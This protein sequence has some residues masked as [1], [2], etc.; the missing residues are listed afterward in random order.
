MSS[1]RYSIFL[2][3]AAAIALLT[4]RAEAKCRLEPYR[5]EVEIRSSRTRKPV[6]GVRLA[7]FANGSETGMPSGSAPSQTT[8]G[9]DGKSARTYLFDTYSGSGVLHAER[10]K[11]QLRTLEVV[12]VHPDYQVRRV[13]LKR[14]AIS[15]QAA[16]DVARIVIPPVLMDPFEQP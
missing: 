4:A 1:I 14:V 11:A 16:G 3:G 7:V 9:P 12:L 8:T 2:G 13:I 15:P 10:C 5:V 6:P